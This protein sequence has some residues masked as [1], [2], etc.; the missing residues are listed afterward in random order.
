MIDG[1][2]IRDPST[3][4]ITLNWSGPYD[5]AIEYAQALGVKDISRETAEF[6]PCLGN[7]WNAGNV[8]FSG[9]SP[10]TFKEFTEEATST[11]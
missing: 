10:M 3:F 5:K 7:N 1:K 2:W 9:R 11:V 8:G 6:Y 4:G